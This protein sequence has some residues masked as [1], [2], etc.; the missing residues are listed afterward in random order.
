MVDFLEQNQTEVLAISASNC[1]SADW[2]EKLLEVRQD[3]AKWHKLLKMELEASREQ[4]CL[5]LGTHIIAV[6]KKYTNI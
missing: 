2:G 5:D 6:A 4:G 1:L 3:A